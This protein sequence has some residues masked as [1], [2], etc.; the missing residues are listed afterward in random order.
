MSS[1]TEFAAA[2]VE[3][4]DRTLS[5][6]R[7]PGELGQLHLARAIALQ[8]RSGRDHVAVAGE[9]RRRRLTAVATR[10]T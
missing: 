3:P 2:L 4:I 10:S 6:A 8:G 1:G 5:S 7:E 9:R